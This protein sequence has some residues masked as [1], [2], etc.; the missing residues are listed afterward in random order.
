MAEGRP[1][2]FP[3]GVSNADAN[4]FEDL[5]KFPYPDPTKYHTFFDDFDYLPVDDTTDL[6]FNWTISG[7][8]A[9]DPAL[10]DADGGVVA[11]TTATSDNDGVFMQKIGESFLW[12]VGNDLFFKVRLECD[13]ATQSDIVAGLCITDAT[14]LDATDQL[15]FVK[16]DGDTDFDFLIEKNG[17]ATTLAEVA[18]LEDDVAIELAFVYEARRGEFRVYVNDSLVASTQVLTNAPDDEILTPTL[19]V[20]AGEAAAK[21]LS[22][23]YIL[24]SKER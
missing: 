17:T 20:Q 3:N 6:P 23:D 21:T 9:T 15:A 24:A 19:A 2:Y 1:T 16:A 10:A 22:V 12:E 18:T 14:V 4:S 5:A 8:N 7:T 11:L 13:D